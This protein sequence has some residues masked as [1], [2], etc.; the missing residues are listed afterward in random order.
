MGYSYRNNYFDLK[1]ISK[2]KILI[3][4]GILGTILFLLWS[5]I[6]NFIKCNDNTFS[7]K[8]CIVSDSEGLIR[9][10]DNFI[11]FF[12]NTSYLVI[13]LYLIK[14]KNWFGVKGFGFVRKIRCLEG[15]KISI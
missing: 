2:S 15:K 3:I 14:V 4:Y 6:V 8:I 10:F 7:E 11:I 5:I 1:F 9:Y 13:L 12:K